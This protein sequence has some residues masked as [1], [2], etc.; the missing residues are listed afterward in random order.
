M[1]AAGI[2]NGCGWPTRCCLGHPQGETQAARD[3]RIASAERARIVAWLYAAKLGAAA[4]AIANGDAD[5]IEATP[6]ER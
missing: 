3:G 6:P 1:S 2:C 4:V 5:C